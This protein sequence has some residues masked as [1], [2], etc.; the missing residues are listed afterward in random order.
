MRQLIL[1]LTLFAGV[2]AYSQLSLCDCHKYYFKAEKAYYSDNQDST[3]Y[4]YKKAFSNPEFDDVAKLFNAADKVIRI[5]E[6]EYAENL[7]YSAR[8]SGTSIDGIYD[9][10]KRHS[11][12]E[13][14]IDSSKLAK[15]EVDTPNL[16]EFL[17]SELKFLQDR[18]Q[19][20]RNEYSGK[21]DFDYKKL[22]DY[23]NFLM[24][25]NIL[26]RYN[27][28]FP[29][30]NIIGTEGE[31]DINTIL[32]HF[33]IEWIAEIFP[34]LVEAIHKG[35]TFNES[36]LYQ[37]DRTIVMSGVVYVYDPK[38]GTIAPGPKNATIG[39]SQQFYQYYG[40]FD[41]FDSD[42]KKLVWWPFQKDADKNQVNALRVT[43]C[44]DSLEDYMSRRPYIEKISDA[45]FLEL[46]D[47]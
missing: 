41:L 38:L 18:D 46:I 36:L 22:I 13:F 34:A 7:I 39:D 5:G 47:N 28:S 20:I 17:V 45:E 29:D 1:I 37:I 24:L 9:F 32:H 43:L 23:G 16:D 26:E 21:Y 2:N 4:Y 8:K 30:L 15:I 11:K 25:K 44:L 31:H 40:G 27:G 10:V 19:M 3:V 42:S 35:Y 6:L 33:D 12:F 14:M